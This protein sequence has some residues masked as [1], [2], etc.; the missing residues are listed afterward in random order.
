MDLPH[1]GMVPM[2]RKSKVLPKYLD[3]FSGQEAEPLVFFHKDFGTPQSVLN[4]IREW[5]GKHPTNDPRLQFHQIPKEPCF[6][7]KLMFSR[8]WN[9]LLRARVARFPPECHPRE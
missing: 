8:F 5:R 7:S 6:N 4:G 9:P 1:V 2:T 3:V